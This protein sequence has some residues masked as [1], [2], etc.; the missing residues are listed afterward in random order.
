[1][2]LW[3]HAFLA[4]SCRNDTKMAL[5]WPIHRAAGGLKEWNN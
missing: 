2:G 3:D 5:N 4:I 1:M